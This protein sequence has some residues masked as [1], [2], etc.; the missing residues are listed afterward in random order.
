MRKFKFSYLLILLLFSA[1]LPFSGCSKMQDT[2]LKFTGTVESDRLDICS[3]TSGT[4]REISFNEGDTVKAGDIVS[5]LDTSML[6]IQKK[7]AEASVASLNAKLADIKAS[8]QKEQVNAA[9][10]NL[11]Q[12]SA[13]I[14]GQKKILDTLEDSLK[15]LENMY[16][17]S[18]DP[19]KKQDLNQS[20]TE[21]KTKVL[22]TQSMID[23]LGDQ[24]DAA[25]EQYKLLVG[26]PTQNSIDGAQAAV[27]QAKASLD[28][29]NLQIEKA[30]IKSPIDGTVVYK[31]ANLGQVVIPGAPILTISDL[32]NLWI[33]FYIPEKSLNKIKLKQKIKITSDA[34]PDKIFSGEIIF[35]S[36]QGEFT[37][38]NVETK[39]EGSKVY[40][41]FKV[42][43]ETGLDELKPGMMVDTILE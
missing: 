13:N 4:V 3:E 35:I 29:V 17:T 10:A 20:L 26:G 37:P 39:E 21:L 12:I 11:D 19:A 31:L 36:S 25:N 34:Y 23:I 22:S 28:M 8:P 41:A 1:V 42:K 2:S 38:K 30:Q 7:Q 43:L 6:E 15:D 27:D 24:Y 16:D 9:K 40:Y 33:K 5:T 14:E 18:Q 32:K